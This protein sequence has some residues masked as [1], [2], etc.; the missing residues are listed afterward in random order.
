MCFNCMLVC[1]AVVVV[2]ASGLPSHEQHARRTS[3]RRRTARRRHR[4]LRPA[5][6]SSVS[7]FGSTD[8]E[9]LSRVEAEFRRQFD[10]SADALGAMAARVTA[11]TDSHPAGAARSDDRDTAV[12]HRVRGAA[13]RPGRA[14][15]A[16][17]ST[18]RPAGRSPGPAACSIWRRSASSGPAALFVAP[19]ALG[20]RL[21]RVEPV[22]DPERPARPRRDRRRRAV[23]VG[24]AAGDRARRR[25]RCRLHLA[26]PHFDPHASSTAPVRPTT[27]APTPPRS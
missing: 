6:R 3:R 27:G 4:R 21:V 5:A 7:R 24:T 19:G 11:A 15:P 12:R 13:G 26:R 1:A 8:D 2:Q 25:H 17:P 20:P 16:S 9:A 18:T 23:A 10:G 14:A 22:V